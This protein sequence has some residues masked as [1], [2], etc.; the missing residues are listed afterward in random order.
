TKY[1]LLE[2][3]AAVLIA[4]IYIPL[5]RRVQTGEP[6]KGGWYNAFETLVTFIR[7]E[8]AK[9]NLGEHA[10]DQYV[11]FLWTI[12]LFVLFCNLLGMIPFMGSPTASIWVTG[13]LAVCSFVAIHGA[14]VANM[15]LVPYLKSLWPHLD[16]PIPVAG[17]IIKA[18]IC[19]IEIV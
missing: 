11:P 3:V 18:M 15:G 12:F 17:F 19:V 9:P 7:D 5:A 10:A 14:A 1:M 8:V 6:V 16:I 13:G 2:V 4:A